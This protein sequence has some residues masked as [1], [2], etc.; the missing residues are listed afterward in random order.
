MTK[1]GKHGQCLLDRTP[2]VK[3]D[4]NFASTAWT[5][6]TFLSLLKYSWVQSWDND[7]CEDA[8]FLFFYTILYVFRNPSLR[9]TYIISIITHKL[10]YKQIFPSKGQRSGANEEPRWHTRSAGLSYLWWAVECTLSA[11]P[12]CTFT[13]YRNGS[14]LSYNDK[15]LQRNSDSMN[16]SQTSSETLDTC[17]STCSYVRSH[18]ETNR[19]MCAWR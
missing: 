7:Q 2:G 11:Y 18:K 6:T 12:K 19:P 17:P 13:E 9:S 15:Q 10:W 1:E 14:S 3:A 8:S 16:S 4:S 5:L